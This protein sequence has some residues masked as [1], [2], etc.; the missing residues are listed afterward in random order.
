LS[1]PISSAPPEPNAFVET[2]V[3]GPSRIAKLYRRGGPMT[4]HDRRRVVRR[5]RS[6][7]R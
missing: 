2:H 3:E 1:S 4:G 6:G 5:P 7:G